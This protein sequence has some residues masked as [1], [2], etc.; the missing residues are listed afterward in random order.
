MKI[1]VGLSMLE[2]RKDGEYDHTLKCRI[3]TTLIANFAS[4]EDITRDL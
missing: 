1:E 4:T 3:K 2:T